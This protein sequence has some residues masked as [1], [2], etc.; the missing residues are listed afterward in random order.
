MVGSDVFLMKPKHQFIY[1]NKGNAL[2][3][4]DHEKKGDYYMTPWLSQ[5]TN[6]L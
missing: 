5:S 6:E 2:M 4:P 1:P 3:A